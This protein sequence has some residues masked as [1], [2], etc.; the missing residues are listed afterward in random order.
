M[1]IKE[2][3]NMI[4]TDPDLVVKEMKKGRNTPLPDVDKCLNQLEPGRHKINDIAFRP[5]KTV[6]TTV[7]GHDV[8]KIVYV[9]RIA[10][11][12]QKQ[13]VRTA[14]TFAFGNDVEY[15]A[16]ITDNDMQRA[17][18]AC[19]SVMYNAKAG[20]MLKKV[21]ATVCSFKEAA[22]LWFLE[23]QPG[24]NRYGFT[25]KYKLRTALLSPE[26][27]DTLYPYFDEKGD[28]IAF[29]REYTI[30]KDVESMVIIRRFDMYTADII[31]TFEYNNGGWEVMEGY[32]K[33]NT[34][35]KI[36]V[37]YANQPEVE[38]KDVEGLIERLETLLSN[39]ADTNDYHAS[40]K[41][42][43]KGQI[44]EWAQKG[45]SGAVISMDTDADAQYLTW[46]QAP[47][48]VKLEIETL[49][50]MIYS[51]TQTPDVSFD[52][53]KGIGSVSGVALK[54]MFMDAHMK[55]MSKMEVFGDFLQRRIS[56]IMA[57]LKMMNSGDNA[58]VAACDNMVVKPKIRPY[59]IDDESSKTSTLTDAFNGG[60]MSRRTAVGKLGAVNDVDEEME[61]IES[62][63]QVTTQNVFGGDEGYR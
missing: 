13:I 12:L 25:S 18:D 19:Q 43:V 2:I 14:V 34:L 55:A 46:S 51:L 48:S 15:S 3:N 11:A 26:K 20:T 59:M 58:F 52:N 21:A 50:K 42:V 33:R 35:G 47:E 56:V 40:P 16:D 37:I 41:I 23:E 38:W 9:E 27:G 32:P 4:S 36:P 63:L 57:F 29:G 30:K 28:M 6:I 7:N 39:F 31:C 61:R 1:E 49:F 22:E 60:I 10:I 5:N 24:Y 8:P 45:D 44:L 62:D 54:L 17:Y 53:V